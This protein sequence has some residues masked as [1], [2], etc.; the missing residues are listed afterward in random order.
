M[1]NYIQPGHTI[2]VTAP[3]NVESGEL[4]KVGK[5]IGVAAFNATAGEPLEITLEG[6]FALPKGAVVFAEGDPVYF[7]DT[8][9][10]E[11]VSTSGGSLIGAAVTAQA[12][13]DA[14]VRVRLNG[15]TVA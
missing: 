1:K 5:F 8:S 13:G 9:P 4:V 15:I 10:G 14:T 2:T 7:G 3:A 11:A 6:V 12:S